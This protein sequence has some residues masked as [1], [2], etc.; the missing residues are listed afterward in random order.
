MRPDICALRVDVWNAG[1]GENDR[2]K[3]DQL[4]RHFSGSVGF[5]V[6]RG[7]IDVFSGAGV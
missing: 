4:T 2:Q 1:E 3:R 6:A 7:V 5:G